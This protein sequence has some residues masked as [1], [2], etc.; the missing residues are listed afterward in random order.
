MIDK[1]RMARTV[2]RFLTEKEK[3]ILFFRIVLRM[4]QED[5]VYKTK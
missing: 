2:T 3:D 4:T 5:V 1:K